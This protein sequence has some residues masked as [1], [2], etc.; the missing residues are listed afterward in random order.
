MAKKAALS[1]QIKNQIDRYGLVAWRSVTPLQRGDFK[2]YQPEQIAKLKTSIRKNG[3]T[4]PLFI[5]EKS[6]TEN[7]LLDGFHRLI[8]FR[9]LESIDGVD[10]PENVPALFVKCKDTKEAKK[11]LLI[12]N[13]HYAEIQKDALYDFVS[14]LD[15]DELTAELDVPG[16]DFE[17]FDGAGVTDS[18]EK[19]KGNNKCCPHCGGVL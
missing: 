4:T 15:L 16:L 12:L 14:D 18:D 17:A 8:A 7:I 11:T 13:S 19:E 10:V 3:F 6:A 9:E 1:S 2:K 5:W